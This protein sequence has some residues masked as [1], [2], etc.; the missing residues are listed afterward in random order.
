MGHEPH[1][2]R[3]RGC[4]S[5]VAGLSLALARPLPSHRNPHPVGRHSR[6]GDLVCARVG[7]PRRHRGRAPRGRARGAQRVRKR[8]PD[9]TPARVRR[10]P[11]LGVC[12]GA[13]RCFFGPRGTSRSD[14]VVAGPRVVARGTH[15]RHHDSPVPG[16]HHSP[17]DLR[18]RAAQGQTRR[19]LRHSHPPAGPWAIDGRVDGRR[20][21]PG[22]RRERDGQARARHHGLAPSRSG[23]PQRRPVRHHVVGAPFLH[24]SRGA[25]HDLDPAA[26]LAAPH[27]RLRGRG[28]RPRVPDER[29]VHPPRCP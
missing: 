1:P 16:P 27:G 15:G 14:A 26:A 11:V 8:H 23:H 13:D 17:A 3:P 6:I 5:A 22:H 4:R 7:P 9:R 21:R 18:V 25:L 10:R 19:L 20:S 28:S 12:G 29:L 2:R 24:A